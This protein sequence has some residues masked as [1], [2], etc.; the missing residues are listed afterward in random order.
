M[1][2]LGGR[3]ANGRPQPMAGRGRVFWGFRAR[4]PSISDL[5]LNLRSLRLKLSGRL[6]VTSLRYLF[7]RY[8]KSCERRERKRERERELTTTKKKTKRS[9]KEN[10]QEETEEEKKKKATLV[11][12]CQR[13]K[14]RFVDL[15]YFR[16]TIKNKV[17]E[18]FFYRVLAFSSRSNDI[19]PLERFPWIVVELFRY[20]VGSFHCVLMGFTKFF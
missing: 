12:V 7:G 2:W 15:K 5:T 1:R 14:D 9:K 3:P 16:W 6:V 8:P 13:L 4:R 18:F 19:S 17:T 10:H 20:P 11:V